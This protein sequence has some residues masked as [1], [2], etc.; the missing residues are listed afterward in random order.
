RIVGM[1]A[2]VTALAQTAIERA[3]TSAPSG[4]RIEIG[5][6]L[7]DAAGRGGFL[8]KEHRAAKRIP[9]RTIDAVKV[10]QTTRV[11]RRQKR[12]AIVGI[13]HIQIDTRNIG[14]IAA[15]LMPLKEEMPPIII[16]RRGATR[17]MIQNEVGVL[18]RLS[19]SSIA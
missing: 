2:L 12:D 13:R 16:A 4:V 10:S 14:E 5:A 9:G 7:D 18:I 3:Q 19:V 15:V 8:G 17:I 1:D 11:N 6:H